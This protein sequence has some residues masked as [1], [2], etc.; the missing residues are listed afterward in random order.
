LNKD[1]VDEETL[2]QICGW[3]KERPFAEHGTTETNTLVREFGISQI[4]AR[5][6]RS[7]AARDQHTDC[8]CCE[9]IGD[10]AC[11]GECQRCSGSGR[12]PSDQPCKLPH[13]LDC[14][15]SWAEEM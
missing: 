2:R 1:F 3:F 5:M 4:L 10:H 14:N 8:L 7:L 6:L 11:G 13:N 15:C 12:N 9:A